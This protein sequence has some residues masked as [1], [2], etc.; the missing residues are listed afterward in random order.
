MSAAKKLRW[1]KNV[2]QLRFLND[3]YSFV[4]EV[5]RSSAGDF[6]AYYRSY[7]A[8]NSINISEL[9]NKNKEKLDQLYGRNQ[10]TDD[11]AADEPNI[12]C[13]G[14][15]AITHYDK[16]SPNG[17]TEEYEMTSDEIAIHD[18]F[19]KLFKRIALD[20]HPD[21][22]DKNLSESEIESRISMFQEANRSFEEKKYYILLDIAEKL[23]IT[24]PKNYDLQIRWMKREAKALNEKIASEKNKYNFVFSE[25]QT[26]EE[27]DA[28][29]EKFLHQLFGIFVN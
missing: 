29:I 18:A 27:K 13:I 15:T 22:I 24:T 4:Q 6:E 9:D 11:N 26:D 23:N 10:I 28:I 14:D 2:S 20:I 21:R 16:T 19:S 12:D 3:E 25:A 5:A 1:K 17:D 7:C 8:K